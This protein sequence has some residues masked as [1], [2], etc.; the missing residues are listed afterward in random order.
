MTR[1][2]HM[3]KSLCISS[4]KSRFVHAFQQ[5]SLQGNDRLPCESFYAGLG[6]DTLLILFPRS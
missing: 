6:N 4:T 3:N 1:S 5:V 2:L